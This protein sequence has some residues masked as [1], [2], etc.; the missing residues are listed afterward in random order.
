LV[1]SLPGR[2]EAG[3]V[4]EYQL[5]TTVAPTEVDLML[6][7]QATATAQFNRKETVS[8]RDTTTI[9]VLAKG[10]Y[11]QY[12]P[13]LYYQ[14][15]LMG[16]FLMLFESFWAPIEGQIEAIPYYFDPQITPSEF[17][18]WLAS[19]L[20]L[21]L[22][23]RWPENRRRL[24]LA[25]AAYLY[26]KRGTKAGLQKYLEIYTGEEAEIIEHRANNFQLGPDARLGDGI[27]LGKENVPHTFSVTL[28][29]PPVSAP[30]AKSRAERRRER[31]RKELERRQIIEGIIES[32]KPAHTN[33]TL[34]I[35]AKE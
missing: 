8:A 22:D 34:Q 13:A 29:L 18:P 7:S 16:R 30:V 35:E 6:E 15:E 23:E 28:R 3:T 26:R 12:L 4:Y 19:W 20:S 14:D 17:L 1:W 2:V 31:A 10:H 25:S 21:V 11:L 32:E 9:N 27:A 5:P 33:Y 24:L